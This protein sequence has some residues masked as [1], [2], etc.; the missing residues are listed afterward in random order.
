VLAVP[1]LLGE[2]EAVG[3]GGDDDR[4]S[5]SKSPSSVSTVNPSYPSSTFSTAVPRW[6]P[7]PSSSRA[8]STNDFATAP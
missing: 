5:A 2:L 7:T 6:T 1:H 8:A 3:A 4:A